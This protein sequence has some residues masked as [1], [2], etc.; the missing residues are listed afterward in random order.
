[1][2]PR[3]GGPLG[4]VPG[5]AGRREAE[6]LRRSLRRPAAHHRHDRH[7]QRARRPDV[8]RPFPR[9]LESVRRG[10]TRRHHIDVAEDG[11][12]T[13]RHPV[14]PRRLRAGAA[15]PVEARS[16]FPRRGGTQEAGGC[17][18]AGLR[19]G[20]GRSRQDDARGRTHSSCGGRAGFA[21]ALGARLG[22]HE[23]ACAGARDCPR[24]PPAG[25]TAGHRVEAAGLRDRRSGRRRG[26]ATAGVPRAVLR[27]VAVAAGR[28]RELL[29]DLDRHQRRPLLQERARRRLR[30][31]HGRVDQREHPEQGAAREALSVSLLHPRGRHAIVSRPHRQRPRQRHE[32][33]I[34][35]VGRTIRLAPA[36]RRAATV[37]DP[38]RRLLRRAGQLPRHGDRF[39]RRVLHLRPGHDL[40]MAEG[41]PARLRRAH[42]LDDQGARRRQPQPARRRERP[43]GDRAPRA[44][45]AGR[46]AA[47][48]RRR[49][50]DGSGRAQA[51]VLVVL[52][53]RGRH[54]DSGPAGPSPP[55]IRQRGC[56]RS[57]W[58]RHAARS[59]RRP[60]RAAAASRGRTRV[61]YASDRRGQGAGHRARDSRRR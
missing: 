50:D 53:S 26:V 46:P 40:A 3:A 47:G 21:P 51:E 5:R 24:N 20:G 29:R 22:R 52:L 35:R 16:R 15:E 34:R 17:G 42:G 59:S 57:C 36:A 9:L 25:R 14:R 19:H 55:A 37:L 60:A 39:R 48:A 18:P 7:R 10:R 28:R 41:V 13:R 49:G 12:P 33:R 61:G 1:M 56:G 8:A 4:R 23:H 38:G 11:A 32:S 27:G 31:L 6:S 2:F 30:D 43:A 54:G 45:R 58:R 44:R